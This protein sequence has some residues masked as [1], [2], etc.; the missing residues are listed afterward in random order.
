[1]SKSPLRHDNHSLWVRAQTQI[2]AGSSWDE[3]AAEA[4]VEVFDLTEWFWRYK[5]P[6]P[7]PM[8]F[9]AQMTEASALPRDSGW[10]NYRDAQRFANWR[11][12]KA[13]A[14]KAL[15]Q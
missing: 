13:G 7:K 3:I 14:A 5:H 11:K 9:A 1:M 12:A 4:G 6:K 8:V 2:N 15:A 10:H